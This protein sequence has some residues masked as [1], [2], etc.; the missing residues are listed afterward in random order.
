M[1]S[2]L[3]CSVLQAMQIQPAIWCMCTPLVKRL[4]H[5]QRAHI[6]SLVAIAWAPRL[7]INRSILLIELCGWVS[8]CT[9][10]TDLNFDVPITYYVARGVHANTIYP[11]TRRTNKLRHESHGLTPYIGFRTPPFGFHYV[12]DVSMLGL[13]MYAF[14]SHLSARPSSVTMHTSHNNATRTADR[15]SSNLHVVAKGI[16]NSLVRDTRACLHKTSVPPAISRPCH[17][18]AVHLTRTRHAH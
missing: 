15:F 16:H 2:C 6:R 10:C 4:C 1:R 7:G 13:H 5:C 17:H 12:E 3:T 14:P 9:Q 18:R 8:P 11:N